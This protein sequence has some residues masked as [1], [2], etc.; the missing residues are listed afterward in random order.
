MV[1]ISITKYIGNQNSLTFINAYDEINCKNIYPKAEIAHHI[2]ILDGT[3][4]D[5]VDT[6]QKKYKTH[7]RHFFLFSMSLSITSF[8]EFSKRKK[9]IH[10]DHHNTDISGN[11][12][13]QWHSNLAQIRHPVNAPKLNILTL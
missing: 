4:R 7:Y 6:E 13:A 3:T 12:V 8:S 1:A 5:T 11:N 2:N 10:N 9:G